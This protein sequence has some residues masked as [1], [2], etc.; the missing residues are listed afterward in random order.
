MKEKR[1]LFHDPNAP[2]ADSLGAEF[3]KTAIAEPAKPP[4]RDED[5]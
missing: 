3:W 5:A 2:A 4:S 1:E